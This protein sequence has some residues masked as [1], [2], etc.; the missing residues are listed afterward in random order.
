MIALL[1][2]R[3]W[4]AVAIAAALGA[5]HWKAYHLGAQAVQAAW[6]TAQASADRTARAKE[7]AMQAAAD[8]LRKTHDENL[9]QIRR[10]LDAARAT[11][12]LL[13]STPRPTKADPYAGMAELFPAH[14]T[15]APKNTTP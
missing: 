2:W 12:R 9:A 5:S 11:I 8:Q 3:V 7:Q 10:D 4:A 1:S 14:E 15:G 13:H 6:D